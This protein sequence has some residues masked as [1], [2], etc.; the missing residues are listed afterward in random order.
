M[1]LFDTQPTLQEFMQPNIN[2][3][4]IEIKNAQ[5]SDQQLS[6]LH[7]TQLLI[8]YVHSSEQIDKF[9]EKALVEAYKSALAALINDLQSYKGK[10]KVEIGAYGKAD[11]Y[12]FVSKLETVKFSNLAECVESFDNYSPYIFKRD[13]LKKYAEMN[14]LI[15]YVPSLPSSPKTASKA[16]SLI[17]RILNDISEE[18]RKSL[19]NVGIGR[20][21]LKSTVRA[22]IT[23]SEFKELFNGSETTF[24]NRWIEVLNHQK[25]MRILRGG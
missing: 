22:K 19:E 11:K 14:D 6:L 15:S 5:M 2:L 3:H 8:S 9:T 21:G 16:R 24:K 10:I 17:E 4:K 7:T 1:K 20:K 25:K 12:Q 18:E 13:S 23:F